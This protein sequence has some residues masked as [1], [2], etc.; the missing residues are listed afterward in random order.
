MEGRPM[1]NMRKSKLTGTITWGQGGQL[2][3]STLRPASRR[4]DP[5]EAS[6]GRSG[7]VLGKRNSRGLVTLSSFKPTYDKSGLTVTKET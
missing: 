5:I 6:H 1:P 7:K 3:G 2:G 4:T